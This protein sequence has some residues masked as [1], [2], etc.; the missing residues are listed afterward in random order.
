MGKGT[1]FQLV[2]VVAVIR[3]GIGAIDSGKGPFYELVLKDSSG[4]L[5]YTNFAQL[6]H[7]WGDHLMSMK[8]PNTD[9]F[10]LSMANF[11]WTDNVEQPS[12]RFKRS[13]AETQ[14]WAKPGEFIKLPI[15]L[16]PAPNM[17]PATHS[18][19][20]VQTRPANTP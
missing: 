18:P 1:K 10:L 13:K 12:F 4:E 20:P 11:E 16:A 19:A 3:Y 8:L 17:A 14:V 7:N 2:N 6:G 9:P 5:F 15:K